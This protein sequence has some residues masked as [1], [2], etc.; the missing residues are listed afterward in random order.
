MGPPNVGVGPPQGSKLGTYMSRG[1]PIP[2]GPPTSAFQDISGKLGAINLDPTKMGAAGMTPGGITG[3]L[4]LEPKMG[5]GPTI[6]ME[7]IKMLNRTAN[8]GLGQ[9]PPTTAGFG[10]P[11]FSPVNP[12]M[13]GP[14]TPVGNGMYGGNSPVFS[15]QGPM[16]NF[17]TGANGGGGGVP[18]PPGPGTIPPPPTSSQRQSPINMLRTPTSG[19]GSMAG[20]AQLGGGGGAGRGGAAVQHQTQE[21]EAAAAAQA[22]NVTAYSEN[23]TTYFYNPDEHLPSQL[24]TGQMVGNSLLV[25]NWSA[26]AGTPSHVV[27]MKVRNAAP[28]AIQESESK[29]DLLTRQMICH[30]IADPETNDLPAEIDNF[31]S[32]CPL[33]ET[34]NSH[35]LKSSVFG[36]VT[37]VYKAVNIKTGQ[38]MCLRRIHNYRLV[39]TKCM[40][41]VEQ[42]KK[43]AHSNLV[44]LRQVFTSKSFGDHSILFVY[45]YYPGADTLMSRHF[46]N[47]QM[48]PQLDPFNGD[49]SRPYSQSK[50]SMLR[51]QATLS[52]SGGLLAEALIWNYIIQLT[53]ALRY[54]HGAGLACRT[55]DPSKILVMGKH[56]LLLNCSGIFD[57]L[58][59]D[60]NSNNPMTAMSY[61]QQ[62]DLVSL[63][64]IVLALACNSFAAIHR[65]AIQQS[66]ELVASNYSSDL[67]SLIMY[68]LTNPTRIK[69]VNDLMPR[70][71]ARFYTAL[72]SA[73]T[74]ADSLEEELAREIEN[75]RVMRLL[76]KLNTVVDRP[77]FNLDIEWAETGDRYMLKLF[78]DYLF[79]QVTE[80]GRPFLDMAHVIANLNRLD[81][82]IPDL[83]GLMS[84]DGQNILVVSYAEL[85]TCLERSFGELL[86]S[87]NTKP[88][89]LV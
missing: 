69:S 61:N 20:Q 6:N 34:S 64:K 63:G 43:M 82:G 8:P 89:M 24:T 22:A 3:G 78:R 30:T 84:R 58:T 83:I 88:K 42:W 40:G 4:G 53:S 26:Y 60:P 45:D 86:Q 81:A 17:P 2:P 65:E 32:L 44:T 72:E 12:N 59:Y 66:M 50:N 41:L 1:P 14:P 36:Y 55:L 46:N 35:M 75:G 28:T 52:N 48:P 67:K 38:H 9:I 5:G 15:R 29:L 51:H 18:G 10:P 73:V 13:P 16:P 76:T 7:T 33:E 70:V 77:E 80:D 56:R 23:G 49:S 27:A 57:V 47:H 71:G 68:L 21:Q 37:T 31:T 54:I 11:R 62:E 85:K 87:A 39:N 74:R 25:P 19:L 79:H